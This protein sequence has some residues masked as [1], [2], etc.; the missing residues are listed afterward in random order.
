MFP[1]LLTTF[2]SS[3]DLGSDEHGLDDLQDNDDEMDFEP[4]DDE[5]K[6]DTR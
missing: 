2:I 4:E 6:Q 5:I 3:I 1:V